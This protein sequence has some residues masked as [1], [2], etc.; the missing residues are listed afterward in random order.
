MKK[1]DFFI[2]SIVVF[3]F[4]CGLILITIGTIGDY[5]TKLRSIEKWDGKLP[6]VN[7]GVVP[8]IDVNNVKNK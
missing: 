4:S 1:D 5:Y 6:N 2:I 8:F 3:I 7:S